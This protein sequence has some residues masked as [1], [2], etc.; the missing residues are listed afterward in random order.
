MNQPIVGA[1]RRI[2][3]HAEEVTPATRQDVL[4]GGASMAAEPTAPLWLLPFLRYKGQYEVCASRCGPSILRAGAS[5][6]RRNGPARAYCAIAPVFGCRRAG[7][8]SPQAPPHLL[9][10]PIKLVLSITGARSG[11]I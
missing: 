2:F 5:R 7:V 9:A 11:M 4:L 10:E 3:L 6:R 8:D 1:G